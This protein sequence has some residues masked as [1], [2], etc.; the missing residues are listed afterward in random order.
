MIYRKACTL[1]NAAANPF[2]IEGWNEYKDTD[3]AYLAVASDSLADK[4]EK[5]CGSFSVEIDGQEGV[6]RFVDDSFVAKGI[7][8]KYAMNLEDDGLTLRD[9]F[10]AMVLTIRNGILTLCFEDGSINVHGVLRSIEKMQ[11]LETAGNTCSVALPQNALCILEI[12]LSE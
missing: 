2:A 9:D 10:D 8:N 11:L 1:K 3:G 7:A 5:R 6:F 4:K 12:T